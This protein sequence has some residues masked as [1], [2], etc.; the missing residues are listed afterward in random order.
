[1]K[2]ERE[3][4]EAEERAAAEA[5]AEALAQAEAEAAEAAALAARETAA[6]DL[7]VEAETQAQVP[8]GIGCAFVLPSS[9]PPLDFSCLLKRH[10][11]CQGQ[12]HDTLPPTLASIRVR[13]TCATPSRASLLKAAAEAAEAEAAAQAAEAEATAAQAAAVE[14]TAAAARLEAEAETARLEAKAETARLESEA[15]TARLEAE[16]ATVAQTPAATA[17]ENKAIDDAA[18]VSRVER[19]AFTLKS[20]WL[21]RACVNPPFLPL[22]QGVR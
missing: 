2:A 22:Y 3:A 7:E 11:G 5:E 12:V 20:S 10:L 6:R 4:R 17:E 15:E 18:D 16:A 21:Y 13:L 19:V 1:M 8:S 9:P 14:A